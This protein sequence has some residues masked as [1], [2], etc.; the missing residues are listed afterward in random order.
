MARGSNNSAETERVNA[1]EISRS[2]QQAGKKGSG[3][4]HFEHEGYGNNGMQQ[5]PSTMKKPSF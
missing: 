5:N 1:K 3:A 2:E 4:T